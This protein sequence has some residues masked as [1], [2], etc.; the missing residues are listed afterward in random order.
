MHKV[1]LVYQTWLGLVSA[2]IRYTP[3]AWAPLRILSNNRF[4]SSRIIVLPFHFTFRVGWSHC[5]IGDSR[6]LSLYPTFL[7]YA[8]VSFMLPSP[9]RLATHSSYR[10]STIFLNDPP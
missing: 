10:T 6:K 3:L 1:L 8:F 5:R 2:R 7:P 9:L 4:V